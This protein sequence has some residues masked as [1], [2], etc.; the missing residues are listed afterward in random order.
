MSSRLFA[1]QKNGRL[2][3]AC[4]QAGC[5]SRLVQRLARPGRLDRGN[6]AA[7]VRATSMSGA[8]FRGNKV[9]LPSRPCVA[10]GRTMSWRKRW[11]RN[12]AEVKY[13]SDACRRVRAARG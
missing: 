12:W 2:P 10:C 9:A 7:G 6:R 5:R 8:T 3:A 1:S 11:A 13:C 4:R